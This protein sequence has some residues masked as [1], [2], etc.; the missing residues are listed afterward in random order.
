MDPTPGAE[1]GSAPSRLAL[2][3][4]AAVAASDRETSAAGLGY[5]G[6][7]VTMAP[8][9]VAFASRICAVH[10]GDPVAALEAGNAPVRHL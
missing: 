2:I 1:G 4:A 9:R 6:L 10:S 7:S 5:V 3:V 8:V